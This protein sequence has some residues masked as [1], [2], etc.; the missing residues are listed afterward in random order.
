MRNLSQCKACLQPKDWCY[1]SGIKP[2]DCGIEFVILLHPLER[3]RR[4]ASGRMAHLMLKKSHLVGGHTYTHDKT[5]NLLLSNPKYF[6]MVMCLGNDAKNLSAMTKV[7]KKNLVTEDKTPL[8]F[9]VDGTWSTASKTVRLSENLKFLP[10][11]CFTPSNPSRFRVRTQPKENCLS[12]LEAIHQTIELFGDTRGFDIKSR[13]HDHMLEVFDAFVAQQ[14]EY[15]KKLK[16]SSTGLKHRK[17][18]AA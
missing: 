15:V 2:F 14:A 13:K 17:K 10:R 11:I 4:I 8:I 3:R 12:T 1:C 9:V 5:V 7:Q 6:P 16:A 18:K